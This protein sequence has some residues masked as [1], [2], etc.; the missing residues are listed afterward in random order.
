MRPHKVQQETFLKLIAQGV[1]EEPWEHDGHI[2]VGVESQQLLAEALGVS[3]S[4]LYRR[5]QE[6][7]IVSTC[8]SDANGVKTL[9]LRIAQP[10]TV[11]KHKIKDGKLTTTKTTKA[12]PL[13]VKQTV[14]RM[15]KIWIKKGLDPEK[16]KGRGYGLLKGLAQVL[17][18]GQQAA[19][20]KTVLDNWPEYMSGV[21]VI[22]NAE[23]AAGQKV[24]YLTF[25]FPV[26]GLMLRYPQPAIEL[27]GMIAQEAKNPLF[28]AMKKAYME[29]PMDKA[30]LK[31][32]DAL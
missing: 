2:W 22:Q 24:M 28:G 16:I 7:P 20:F 9:L 8:V 13:T 11:T 21:R 26:I 30:I 15:K 25:N 3:V 23:Q 5:M 32:M 17:P 4:T 19:I 12:A 1:Q 29:G 10:V 27:H 6:P 18:E 31:A 14:G